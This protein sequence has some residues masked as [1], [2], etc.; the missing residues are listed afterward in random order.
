MDFIKEI[1]ISIIVRC[2]NKLIDI[3]LEKLKKHK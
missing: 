3:L 1:L 2:I